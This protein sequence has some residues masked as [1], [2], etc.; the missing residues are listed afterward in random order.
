MN[1]VSQLLLAAL[2]AS[3]GDNAPPCPPGFVCIEA[4]CNGGC[5]QAACPPASHEA[6]ARAC[7]E[8]VQA[9]PAVAHREAP[10][11]P[12]AVSDTAAMTAPASGPAVPGKTRSRAGFSRWAVGAEA[13]LNFGGNLSVDTDPGAAVSHD[14]E[15]APAFLLFADSLPSRDLS[16]GGILYSTSLDG[17]FGD[18]S[19]LGLGATL[20]ARFE[21]RPN[22]EL[23]PGLLLA[24]QKMEVDGM[25]GSAKGIGVGLLLD[26]A[27]S[28]GDS[29]GIVS[30]IGVL[31]Q[32]AGGNGDADLTF[33]PTVFWMGGIEFGT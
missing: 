15:S 19:L 4:R 14:T 6:P 29:F 25:N 5:N 2:S 30:T 8:T 7:E 26:V 20:K 13:G 28:L 31:G 18:A 22:L 27:T 10:P 33:G 9:V 24:Y 16:V 21:A 3:P 1:L 12:A 17:N 23:R 32:P 11:P